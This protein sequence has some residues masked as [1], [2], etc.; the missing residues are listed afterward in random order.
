MG[1]GQ[2]QGRKNIP[3][4][5]Q[6]KDLGVTFDK[7]MK[8]RVHINNCVNKANRT[9]GL[10]KRTF[11]F[12]DQRSLTKLFKSLVRPNLEYC[13]VVWSPRYKKDINALEAV[14]RRATKLLP[15]TKDLPYYE[16]LKYLNLPTLSYR[17]HRGDMIQVFKLISGLEDIDYTKFFELSEI[18]H[19]RGHRLKLRK[20]N[21]SK[22]IRKYFFSLRIVNSWNNLPDEIVN[23]RTLNQF[24]N[25]F[26]KFM[27][28]T[29]YSYE[30]ENLIQ[31]R[32]GNISLSFQP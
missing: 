28:A 5:T 4:A 1:T 16:R 12:L 21:A 23:S 9:V 24:K 27:G 29:M 32:G 3:T 10:I 7:D 19:T 13:N 31:T 25:R 2:D 14:Q 15:E 11:A 22:D 20:Q 8:F 26:D 17:R 18:S 6:E 30:P